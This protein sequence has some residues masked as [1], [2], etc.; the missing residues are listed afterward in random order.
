MGNGPIIVG[1]THSKTIRVRA[2]VWQETTFEDL[3]DPNQT[4]VKRGKETMFFTAPTLGELFTAVRNEEPFME[5]GY[6]PPPIAP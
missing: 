4:V 5:H 1:Q 3:R 2:I 6:P